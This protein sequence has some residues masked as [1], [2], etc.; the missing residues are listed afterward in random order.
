MMKNL[1][2]NYIRIP[3]DI[4]F[5]LEFCRDLLRK[6]KDGSPNKE[7][8]V[9]IEQLKRLRIIEKIYVKWLIIR[10]ENS[11]LKEIE[12]VL[13]RLLENNREINLA[14]ISSMEGLPILSVMPPS[15]DETRF[16]AM[17][18]A[19]L[20]LSVRSVM[21]MEIG[22]FKQLY[23]KGNDGYLLI[24]D[25]KLAVLAVSTTERAKLGLLFLECERASH[26]ILKI[27][28]KEK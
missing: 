25:S 6:I 16:S 27:L 26:E 18:A 11:F 3:E 10:E 8:P 19:L 1:E 4:K 2:N 12:K 28:K 14:L 23:I 20:S 7:L 9:S 22:G 17:V 21:D 13:R 24:F 5:L 15:F